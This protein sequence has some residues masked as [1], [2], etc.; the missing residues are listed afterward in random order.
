MDAASLKIPT[1]LPR[2]APVATPVPIP[3]A[4][5][6]ADDRKAAEPMGQPQ[7]FQERFW[8]QFQ[9]A[10]FGV[11]LLD[12]K[13]VL[14]A[15]NPVLSEMLGY[16]GDE[17]YGMPLVDLA[18]PMD[19]KRD[20]RLLQELQ[21][22]D[23]MGTVLETRL[24]RK[25]GALVWA[26]LSL[27]LMRDRA[28][29]AEAILV[30]AEDLSSGWEAAEALHRLSTTD[31]LTGLF[32][33]RGF[34][35]LAELQWRIA[36]RKQR[37]LLL[38]YI[39]VDG[40]KQ[41][42]DRLGHAA[43][44]QLL[45]ET[46]DVLRHICRDTDV[47]ARI[48]GDEFVI[49]AVE[50]VEDSVGIFRE[51]LQRAVRDRNA[52]PGRD[53]FISV[54]LGAAYFGPNDQQ[55]IEEMLREADRRMYDRKRGRVGGSVAPSAEPVP[56]VRPGPPPAGEAA[57][58][59]AT[60]EDR[61]RQLTSALEEIVSLALSTAEYRDRLVQMHRRAIAALSAVTETPASVGDE[62]EGSEIGS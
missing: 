22:G 39:D 8:T 60:G 26:K 15:S 52:V 38:L 6:A 5:A 35:L 32:N 10:S 57:P 40:L 34:H 61:V 59:A 44:D 48:G 46:A 24:L 16:S 28:G 53:F 41:V 47:V 51:R 11:A 4:P 2:V 9:D 30:I 29:A 56:L 49:L 3:P 55:T 17:L 27:H 33:R 42:N 31:E 18:H 20:T 19:R 45:R 36:R 62:D 54:S 12:G 14:R 58:P 25:T 21:A 50:A 23:S 13:G 37:E 43:G 7:P 1:G